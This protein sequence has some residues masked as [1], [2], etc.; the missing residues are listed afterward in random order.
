MHRCF[1]GEMV[2]VSGAVNGLLIKAEVMDLLR[3]R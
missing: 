2:S 1:G 3:F